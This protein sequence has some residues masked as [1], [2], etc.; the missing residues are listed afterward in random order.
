[1]EDGSC[2]V[3][4]LSTCPE[5]FAKELIKKKNSKKENLGDNKNVKQ[6]GI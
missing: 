1:L 4:P 5:C 2:E 3:I 6:P